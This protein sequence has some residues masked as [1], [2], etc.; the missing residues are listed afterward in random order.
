MRSPISEPASVGRSFPQHELQLLHPPQPVDASE[1][2]DPQPELHPEL[3]PELHPELQLPHK[4]LGV[5]PGPHCPYGIGGIWDIWG[6]GGIMPGTYPGAYG[7][8]A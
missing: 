2:G 5:Q 1:T 4:L 6:I 3:Q 7:L 8:G